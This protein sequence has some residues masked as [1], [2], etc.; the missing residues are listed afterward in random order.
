MLTTE[1]LLSGTW[2][3]MIALGLG[4]LWVLRRVYREV[5]GGLELRQRVGALEAE[6]VQT[7][8]S[9]S[10]V[11]S[12][13]ATA[14]AHALSL[15][16]Q[17]TDT[18]DILAS[19]EYRITQLHQEQVHH[20]TL[21]ATARAE[22]DA[23]KGLLEEQ[24]RIQSLQEQHL[25]ERHDTALAELKAVNER[26]I[27]SLRDQFRVLASD[28][29]TSNSPELL[30]LVQESMAKFKIEADGDWAQRQAGIATLVKPLEE[31]L[32]QYQQRLQQAES[33]QQSALG[34]IRQQLES[35]AH[36]SHTL[37]G[38]T[39]RLRI[40]LS[41]GQA[42]GRWGEETLRRVVEAAQL[43]VHCDFTEQMQ[44][45]DSKPDLVVHLP[46]DRV[47]LVDSKVPDLEFLDALES[48]DETK[49]S[50]ALASHARKLRDTIRQLAE[51]D[52]PGQFSRS[53][54]HVILFLPAESLF[55]AALE[56]DRDL[57]VWAARHRVLLATP[58]SLIALLRSV[59]ISWQQQEQSQNAR[60]IVESARTLYERVSK[61]TEHLEAIRDGLHRANRAYDAAVGSYER[62]VRPAGE[63]LLKLGGG[64][65]EK[66]LADIQGLETRLRSSP[67]EIRLVTSDEPQKTS[68]NGD[69]TKEKGS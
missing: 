43:S 68:D 62:S 27:T 53:L 49:R 61:F 33:Q 1:W 24:R 48:A 67:Q 40:V 25:R 5:P 58:A 7:R 38:E 17:L 15:E 12:A 52:Y 3:L 34:Q 50:A 57:I 39:Q 64:N 26:A 65:P 44:V 28:A 63:R 42:R 60:Q 23:A 13:R 45:G 16:K 54:D 21:L 30:K 32:R 56:G 2:A 20:V 29:L 31:Q 46:G 11:S 22:T 19:K 4:F 37:S 14:E 51:R 10:Q 35:L 6:L 47:I 66:G 41:S 9:L 18:R 69:E 8:E 59:A 36:Q 55:S